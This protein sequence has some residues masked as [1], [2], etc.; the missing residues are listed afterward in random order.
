MTDFA[1]YSEGYSS[2]CLETT[3][4][5]TTTFYPRAQRLALDRESIGS[6]ALSQGATVRYVMIQGKDQ[7]TTQMT[8]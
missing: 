2:W 5:W 4:T 7:N 6:C 8:S 1:V 3:E